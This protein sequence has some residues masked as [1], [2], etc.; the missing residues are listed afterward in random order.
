MLYID[1]KFINQIAPYLRNFKKKND[2][3]YNFSCPICGDSK[4]KTKKSRGYL[5]K[6]H[7]AMFFKCHNDGMGMSLGNF[8][9]HVAPHLYEQYALER[10]KDGASG[11][12]A[13]KEPEFNIPKVE[14]KKFTYDTMYQIKELSPAHFARVYVE[15]RQIPEESLSRVFFTEDWAKTV[16]HFFPDKYKDLVPEEPRLVLPFLD[17]DG[18][19][20]GLQ[21]RSFNAD[22]KLR[23]VTARASN[24]AKLVF[25]AEKLKFNQTIYVVEGPIDSLF[26]PNCVAVASSDLLS[27]QNRLGNLQDVVYVF[28]NEPRHK[29]LIKLMEEAIETE[30]QIVIW[31]ATIKEKDINEMILS[32]RSKEDILQIIRDR[33]FSGIVAR[34]KFI[35]WKKC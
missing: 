13:H 10:F 21:G 6:K 24:D 12:Q 35:E 15:G 25:G 7:N 29:E 9:K 32:G 19:L 4:K 33:T 27:I 2:Y 8:I 26:I 31:P 34:M 22:P 1:I 17:T 3:L 16:Q 28:D 20:T 14:F 30:N 18:N 5:Y 11:K 23:Y